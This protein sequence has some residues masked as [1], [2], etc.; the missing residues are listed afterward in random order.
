MYEWTVDKTTGTLSISVEQPCG[1]VA[2]LAFPPSRSNA[3]IQE[4]Q[5][6]LL[7]GFEGHRCIGGGGAKVGLGG[8]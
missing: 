8:A 6:M 1:C 5:K 4:Y 3:E 2:T 7:A